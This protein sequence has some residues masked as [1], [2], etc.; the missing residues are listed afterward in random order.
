MNMIKILE[1][2]ISNSCEVVVSKNL[3]KGL[4]KALIAVFGEYNGECYLESG[5]NDGVTIRVEVANHSQ[6]VEVCL[7]IA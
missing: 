3:R 7:L 4:K 1:N 6:A 5:I 2:E